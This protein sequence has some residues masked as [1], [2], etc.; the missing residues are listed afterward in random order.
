MKTVILLLVL[1]STL[2]AKNIYR[3]YSHEGHD[4]IKVY[5]VGQ[6]GVSGAHSGNCKCQVPKLV[7]DTIVETKVVEVIKLDTVFVIVKDKPDE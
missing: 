6:I 4:Y 3:T 1:C 7:H 5:E 2:T